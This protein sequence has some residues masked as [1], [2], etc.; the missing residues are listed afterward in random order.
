[1]R[2]I[3][4]SKGPTSQQLETSLRVS[5]KYL[6]CPGNA[7]FTTGSDTVSKATPIPLAFLEF[8][9]GLSRHTIVPARR[10]LPV[11]PR[12]IQLLKNAVRKVPIRRP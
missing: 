4:T 9:T 7:R 10:R 12:S 3:Q 2:F 5:A 1:M 8:E 11:H 6:D